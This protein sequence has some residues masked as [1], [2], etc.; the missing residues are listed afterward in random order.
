MSVVYGGTVGVYGRGVHCTVGVQWGCK[1]EMYSEFVLFLGMILSE[2][3]ISDLA[4]I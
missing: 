2:C 3:H 1:I 4:I